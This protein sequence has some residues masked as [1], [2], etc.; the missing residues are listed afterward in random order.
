MAK[1]KK[2]KVGG[3]LQVTV[4]VLTTDGKKKTKTVSV[5]AEGQTLATVL[6][7]NG[8]P[9]DK[10]DLFLNGAP[11]TAET[12]VGG[13]QTIELKAQAV[14]STTVEVKERPQGS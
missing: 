10:H 14:Q 4:V 11:A 3:G 1:T 8:F 12:L 7:S 5:P 2:V 13:P 9:A 6:S